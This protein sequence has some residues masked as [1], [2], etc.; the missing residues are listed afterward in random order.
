MCLA[1]VCV[2]CVFVCACVRACGC[3]CV[4][5]CVCVVRK[6]GTTVRH[7]ACTS[8]TEELRSQEQWSDTRLARR[9][10]TVTKPGTTVRHAACTSETE[11]LRS[12]EQRSDMRLALLKRKSYEARNNGQTCG[13]HFRKGRVTKSLRRPDVRFARL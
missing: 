13:L 9:L 11:Q 2:L 8:E 4:C 3:M 6:P 12:Q 7:T 5:V 10:G 1:C